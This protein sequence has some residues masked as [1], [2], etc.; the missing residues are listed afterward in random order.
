VQ[1]AVLHRR[2]DDAREVRPA[3]ERRRLRRDLPRLGVRR[4]P[5]G[6][7]EIDAALLL[8]RERQ[9]ARRPDRV[10]DGEHAVGQVDA[11]VGA[12]RQAR[13]KGILGLRRAHRHR[14]HLAADGVAQRRRVGNRG[15]VERVEEQRHALAPQRLG[16]R[17]E[18]DRVGARHLLDQADDLH[19][20]EPRRMKSQGESLRT[21]ELCQTAARAEPVRPLCGT[22]EAV[23]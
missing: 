22:A 21:K 9:R 18:L 17:V 16:L 15:G 11:A 23:P 6:D 14:D 1:G 19:V 8:E 13:A 7:D 5:A 12:E 2:L 4:L 10:G 3:Q 20:W